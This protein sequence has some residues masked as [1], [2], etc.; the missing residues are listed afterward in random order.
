M[1]EKPTKFSNSFKSASYHVWIV[2]YRVECFNLKM[3]KFYISILEIFL[4]LPEIFADAIQNGN[5]KLN[6]FQ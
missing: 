4:C 1:N 6:E 5:I 2:D 3:I